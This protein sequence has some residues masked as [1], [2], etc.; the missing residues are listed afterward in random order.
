MRFEELEKHNIVKDGK[1]YTP[2]ATC[3]RKIDESGNAYGDWT[4]IKTAEEVAN[5][6]INSEPQPQQPTTEETLAKELAGM[7]IDNMKKDL[8]ITNALQSLASLK[9]EVMNLKGGIA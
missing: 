8:I 1:T 5:T 2:Q 6:I 9:I 7:K 4:I 3:E